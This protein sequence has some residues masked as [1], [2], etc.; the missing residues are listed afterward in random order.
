MIKGTSVV[1]L[2]EQGGSMFLEEPVQPCSDL[3]AAGGE[4]HQGFEPMAR[5]Q[6]VDGMEDQTDFLMIFG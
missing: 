4:A 6:V 2:E 5:G 1:T 3:R